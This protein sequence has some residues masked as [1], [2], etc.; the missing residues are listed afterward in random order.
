MIQGFSRFS[1]RLKNCNNRQ[2]VRGPRGMLPQIILKCYVS[3]SEIANLPNQT[4]V[5]KHG[6]KIAYIIQDY[7]YNN[8]LSWSQN[9]LLRVPFDPY[10]FKLVV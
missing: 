1:N 6:Q 8:C 2:L 7:P 5:T 4:V 9:K 3:G 10:K